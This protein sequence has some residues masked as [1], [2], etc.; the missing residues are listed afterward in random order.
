MVSLA[1]AQ[2]SKT[3]KTPPASVNQADMDKA[4]KQLQDVMKDLPPEAKQIMDSMGINK[5]LSNSTKDLKAKGITDKQIR[6]A[7]DDDNRLVPEKDIEF[8]KKAGKKIHSDTELKLF[9]NNSCVEILKRVGSERVHFT[10]SLYKEMQKST[11]GHIG[12]YS[13]LGDALYLNGLATLAL[14]AYAK[15]LKQNSKVDYNDLNNFAV[16]CNI[17]GGPYISIPVLNFLNTKIPDNPILLN[18]IGQCWYTCGEKDSCMYYLSRS[19]SIVPDAPEPNETIALVEKDN[20]D[21]NTAEKAFKN[22]FR[23]GFSQKKEQRAKDLGFK[24][25]KNDYLLPEPLPY[26]PLG[27]AKITKPVFQEDIPN[28]ANYMGVYSGWAAAIQEERDKLEKEMEDLKKQSPFWNDDTEGAINQVMEGNR[29]IQKSGLSGLSK[30]DMNPNVLKIT[31]YQA[32]NPEKLTG[33]IILQ[34]SIKMGRIQ[35]EYDEKIEIIKAASQKIKGFTSCYTN[36][37]NYFII[38]SNMAASEKLDKEIKETIDYETEVLYFQMYTNDGITFEIIKTEAKIKFLDLLLHASHNVEK[39]ADNCDS[40]VTKGKIELSKW[41]DTHCGKYFDFRDILGIVEMKLDCRGG[42][43]DSP[44]L[45]LKDVFD[46]NNKKFE[47]S[48][49]FGLSVGK[50]LL[51]KSTSSPID[52]TAKWTQGCYV[53][54]NDK[55]GVTDFGFT[56]NVKLNAGVILKNAGNNGRA[57]DMVYKQY[58]L[59]YKDENESKTSLGGLPKAEASLFETE[60]RTSFMTGDV[61]ATKFDLLGE[62]FIP[63]DKPIQIINLKF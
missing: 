26:D 23:N 40:K 33:N 15:E 54:Y 38:Q 25:T 34:H 46:E 49:W 4:M 27:F 31:S 60:G 29:E 9:V 48:V 61:K 45:K 17:F 1:I 14:T 13:I 6:E 47:S 20:G 21:N 39:P 55:E 10:D 32:I 59:T 28:Y 12:S 22:S 52:V 37:N 63:S 16:L 44:V 8:I 57:M 58:P 53:E 7:V 35:E 18:N 56:E 3:T 42:H 2:T 30:V 5:K 11:T 43:F 51:S 41:I 19:L 62:K 36:K 24:I 50:S